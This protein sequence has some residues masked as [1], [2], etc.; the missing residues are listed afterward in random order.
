MNALVDAN[1]HTGA[2]AYVYAIGGANSAYWPVGWPGDDATGG[3]GQIQDIT[4]N[5]HHATP[6]NTNPADL[7]EV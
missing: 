3:T 4:P 7:V 1:N 6:I 2:A 5:G